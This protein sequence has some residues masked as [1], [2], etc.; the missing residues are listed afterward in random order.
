MYT[1]G[2]SFFLPFRTFIKTFLIPKNVFHLFVHQEL[3]FTITGE[4][5]ETFG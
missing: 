4:K 3:S 2:N 1:V 5:D